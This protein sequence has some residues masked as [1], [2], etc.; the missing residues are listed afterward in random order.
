MR[1]WRKQRAE[2]HRDLEI[3]ETWEQHQGYLGDPEPSF[4]TTILGAEEPVETDA[5]K[6]E[7]NEE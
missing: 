2:L 5:P 6:Q 7:G 3:M 4:F 1:H